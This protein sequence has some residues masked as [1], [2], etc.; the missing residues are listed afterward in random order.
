[1]YSIGEFSKI[2]SLSIKS[3][4]LYHEK[5]L[6]APARVDEWSNYRYYD[7]KNY[8]T[9]RAI[10]ILKSFDFSLAEIKA[11]LDECDDDMDAVTFLEKKQAELAQKIQ[12]YQ[13]ISNQ[14]DQTIKLERERAMAVKNE[15]FTVEEKSAATLL[16]AGYRMK[17]RYDEI[18]K[19]FAKIGKAAGRYICGKPMGL[20][21][22]G[23]YKENDAD[24]EACFPVRKGFD[25]EGV[26]VR[27]LP[28]GRCI[29][30]LHKGPYDALH[31]SYKIILDY[32]KE[33]NLNIKIPT[34]EVYIKGPGMIFKGNPNN[35]LTEIILMVE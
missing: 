22:D 21:Y 31:E 30:L 13:H 33:N 4:R 11:I 24:I 14:I 26:S 18:G 28:G 17:G 15:K 27:E 25:A 9:A 12:R 35:Y 16:I 5:G 20:Y 7:D 19:G 23:E 3:L 34:R 6:L 29:S 2:T 8:E 10:R 1:M 32:I